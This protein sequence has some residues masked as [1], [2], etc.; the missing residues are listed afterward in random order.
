MGPHSYFVGAIA[1]A[2]AII[3]VGLWVWLASTGVLIVSNVVLALIGGALVAWSQ[4]GFKGQD[5]YDA[6]LPYVGGYALVG[7][8]VFTA[9]VGGLISWWLE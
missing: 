7:L 5:N 8:S 1:L 6:M 4:L 2:V 3:Y 9:I